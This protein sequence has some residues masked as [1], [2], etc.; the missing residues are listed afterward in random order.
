MKPVHERQ[1]VSNALE[2]IHGAVGMA[3]DQTW[4]E[5]LAVHIL[6]AVIVITGTL[7]A[8]IFYAFS[9]HTE[10]G[11]LKHYETVFFGSYYLCVLEQ[12]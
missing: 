8:D 3:I 10:I 9:I 1:I 11:I 6:F 2:Q 12:D 5:E 7:G 4:H